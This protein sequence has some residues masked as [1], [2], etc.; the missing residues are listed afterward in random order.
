MTPFSNVFER[1][2]RKIKDYGLAKMEESTA[3]DL[4]C[5]WLDSACV[6]FLECRQS[7]SRDL[8]SKTFNGTLTD[9][10][11]EILAYLMVCEW[12]QPFI[13]NIMNLKQVLSSTDFKIYS[14]S[15]HLSELINVQS[16]VVKETERLINRYSYHIDDYSMLR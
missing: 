15:N 8:D 11:E 6:K 14:Q 7:L 3:E 10:E 12:I 2:L 16:A 1:F 13:T 4:M 9:L 5:G